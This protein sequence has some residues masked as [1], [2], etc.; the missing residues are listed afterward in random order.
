MEE[1]ATLGV[2]IK[3]NTLLASN[4]KVEVMGAGEFK[5]VP[6]QVPTA[7]GWDQT[8]GRPGP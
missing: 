3:E 2:V 6:K 4:P 7:R 8:Q 1:N 5:Q